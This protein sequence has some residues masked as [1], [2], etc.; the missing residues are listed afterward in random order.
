VVPAGIIGDVAVLPGSGVK[1]AGRKQFFFEKKHQ[2][3]F[4]RF[5]R[6][7]FEPGFLQPGA[8]IKGFLLLFFKKEI[9]LPAF[10]AKPVARPAAANSR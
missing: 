9:R 7:P 1:Q 2:K 5:A 8:T 4:V 3:T 6:S 10:V